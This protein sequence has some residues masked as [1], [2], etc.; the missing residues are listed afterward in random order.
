MATKNYD[1]IVHRLQR[2]LQGQWIDY[3]PKE[4]SGKIFQS[5][6]KLDDFENYLERFNTSILEDDGMPQINFEDLSPLSLGANI[7]HIDCHWLKFRLQ[8]EE[9]H[10]MALPML[11]GINT[12][13]DKSDY[14]K[15]L[16]LLYRR[17]F[18]EKLQKE[19]RIRR[20]LHNTYQEILT[21]SKQT[22]SSK[23][24]GIDIQ[25]PIGK[26]MKTILVD[27]SNEL[28]RQDSYYVAIPDFL[29]TAGIERY[30]QTWSIKKALSVSLQGKDG[31]QR[32]KKSKKYYRANDFLDA[33]IRCKES[34][35]PFD[36]QTESDIKFTISRCM[37]EKSAIHIIWDKSEKRTKKI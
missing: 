11:S 28:L 22:D 15:G 5:D 16:A 32:V 17:L 14:F 36:I 8:D 1:D 37:K 7:A 19:N 18:F 33:A 4:Y 23:L 24:Q 35:L 21:I 3:P 26:R 12:Q 13:E 27:L 34:L 25:S 2:K 31:I 30:P 9:Y 6:E 29:R 10:P 20:K